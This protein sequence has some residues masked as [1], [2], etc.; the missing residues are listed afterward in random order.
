MLWTDVVQ[1][2]G[3]IERTE[4]AYPFS[5]FLIA[6][7]TSFTPRLTSLSFDAAKQWMNIGDLFQM[8]EERRGQFLAK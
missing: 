8:T 6:F 3:L 5:P 7:T 4:V 1:K 2:T